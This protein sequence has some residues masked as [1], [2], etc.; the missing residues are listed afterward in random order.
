VSDNYFPIRLNTLRANFPVNFDVF[1]KVSDKYVHYIRTLDPMEADR[2]EKLKSKGVKKLFIEPTSESKYLEYLDSGLNSLKD[3]SKSVTEKGA[4]AN[5]SLVT[6]AENAE[7]SLETEQ[8]FN[9]TKQQFG[10][11]VDFLLSDRGAIKSILGSAGSSLDNHQHA[12]TVASLTLAVATRAGITD[13]KELFEMG[14]AGL[15]HDIAKSKLTFDL[16]RPKDQLTPEERKKYE[17]HAADGAAMLSGK[18]FVSPHILG[19]I[20]NHHEIGRG[21]GFPE[22]KDLSK[23]AKPYQ[24]LNLVNDFE[25]YCYENKLEPLKAIDM[26]FESR[27]DNFDSE[28]IATLA[29]VL[30]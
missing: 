3:T 11:V 5:D 23:L 19:L 6:A 4:L 1:I 24:I 15:L 27:V 13:S 26:F 21:R 14:L 22:K 28:L 9:Q 25:S 12:A 17:G 18:P 30:T 29:T 2:L 7:R 16:M 20:A 10:K 8:G